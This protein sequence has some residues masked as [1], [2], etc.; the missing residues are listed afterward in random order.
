[1]LIDTHIHLNDEKYVDILEN[2]VDEIKKA[3]VEKIIVPGYDIPSSLRAIELSKTYPNFIY[4]A[5]GIHPEQAQGKTKQELEKEL[6]ELEEI[7]A[8]NKVVAIGEIGLDYYWTKETKD[9]QKYILKAQ[10]EIAEKYNLPVILHIREATADILEI[11]NE[12]S[13][14]KKG[15]FHCVPFNEHLIRQGLKL[16]YY[17]SFSGNITFKNAKPETSIE[18]VPLDKILIETDGPYLTPEPFRGRINSSK[19]LKYILEKITT[20][21][22]IPK[23]ELEKQI[24]KNSLNIYNIEE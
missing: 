6:K 15:I 16:G 22:Q 17:I 18:L 5:V 19:Y 12:H 8:K 21:K 1:M 11:L 23:D 2:E 7:V 9:M 24:Y 14:T 13:P 4:P 3:G 20:V 10:L